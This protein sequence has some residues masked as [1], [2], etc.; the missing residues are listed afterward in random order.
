MFQKT[1]TRRDFENETMNKFL[2]YSLISTLTYVR[3]WVE[4]R[5]YRSRILV[6][7]CKDYVLGQVIEWVS[8]DE[9]S[10]DERPLAPTGCS[11]SLL[12]NLVQ[13][14]SESFPE[15]MARCRAEA[16]AN[17][18]DPTIKGLQEDTYGPPLPP[19]ASPRARW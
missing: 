11:Y 4:A 12:I 1:L 2:V 16:Q 19:R 10:H 5:M 14:E 17:G 13:G 3:L 9:L 18:V 6:W 7:K 8:V 15:F